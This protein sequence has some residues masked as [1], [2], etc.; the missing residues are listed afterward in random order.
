MNIRV[1]LPDT[2]EGWEMLNDRMAEVHSE[3]I[4]NQINNL[5]CSYEKKLE[6]L[7]GVRI[8]IEEEGRDETN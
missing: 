2:E 4:I 8:K 6:V 7:E 5:P 1:Q 3:F